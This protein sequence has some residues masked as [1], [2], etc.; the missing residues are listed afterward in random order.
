MRFCHPY[1]ARYQARFA[2]VPFDPRDLHRPLADHS[3]Y[4][5]LRDD[6]PIK[7]QMREDGN[8]NPQWTELD[9]HRLCS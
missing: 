3:S 9:S 4:L 5:H 1:M 8:Y 2:K 6:R 7:Q